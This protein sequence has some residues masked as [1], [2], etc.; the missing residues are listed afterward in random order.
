MSCA[1][2]TMRGI[3]TMDAII[4]LARPAEQ[5]V[6]KATETNVEQQLEWELHRGN[7]LITCIDLGTDKKLL[8]FE[9]GRR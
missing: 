6:V 4:R 5:Y 2:D 7:R 9:K 1:W 3:N 8:V